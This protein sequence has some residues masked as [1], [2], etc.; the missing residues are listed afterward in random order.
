MS[1]MTYA[2]A[3]KLRLTPHARRRRSQAIA[4]GVLTKGL[5]GGAGHVQR[6]L[7]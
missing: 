7:P 1:Q 3:P 6:P 5:I 2:D 4:R